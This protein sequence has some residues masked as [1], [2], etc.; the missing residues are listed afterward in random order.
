MMENRPPLT[1]PDG[2]SN[3]NPPERCPRP[4]YSRDSTQ[5]HQEIHQED[6]SKHLFAIKVEVKEEAENPSVM[7]DVPCKEEEIPLEI[8]TDPGDSR[9]TQRDIKVKEEKEERPVKVI[10]EDIAIEIGTD[11][12]YR[13]YDTEEPP[14]VLSG[15]EKG[16]D[17]TSDSSEDDDVTSDSSEDD[18]VTSDSSEKKHIPQKFHAAPHSADMQSDPSKHGRSVADHSTCGT[19]DGPTQDKP[20]P[21]SECG[22]SYSSKQ[23]LLIHQKTHTG[24]KPYSCS[25]CGRR[26]AERSNLARHRSTHVG[27]KPYSCSE[28]GKCF[29]HKSS[30]ITHEKIHTGEKPYSCSE[31]G[32]TFSSQHSRFTHQRTHTG[33]KPY[34]CSECAKSFTTKSSLARHHTAHSGEKPYTCSECGKCFADRTH[35]YCHQKSHTGEKPFSCPECGKSF[36]FKASLVKHQRNRTC[37]VQFSCSEC[38]RDF[39]RK[40]SLVVHKEMHKRLHLMFQQNHKE[41]K[42]QGRY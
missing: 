15:G 8:R 38:G 27:E 5:E 22:K 42:P 28:C 36:A 2:S 24:E 29:Y 9:A 41:E 13:R 37:V 4:L 14:A 1:S 16:D 10:E 40:S 32:E 18:D 31:C 11:G 21:C 6:Q 20:Y 3:R 35:F 33:E 19:H 17:V 30:L 25:E 7:G 12:R 39:R 34:S 23:G 26:F